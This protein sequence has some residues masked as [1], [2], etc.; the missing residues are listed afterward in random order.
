MSEETKL[1]KAVWHV[2]L[3][4][5]GSHG[6]GFWALVAQDRET[7]IG[8][9][10]SCLYCDDSPYWSGCLQVALRNQF[11]DDLLERIP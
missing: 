11:A 5:F 9:E 8:F 1:K 6:C 3:A 2:P 10:G 4:P 7:I